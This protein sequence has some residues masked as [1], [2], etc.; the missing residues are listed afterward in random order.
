[1]TSRNRRKTKKPK[2]LKTPSKIKKMIKN[3]KLKTSH[4]P[5][6]PSLMGLA[7]PVFASNGLDHW[8]RSE[9]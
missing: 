2:K 5:V 6:P 1:M 9:R 4:I 7:Q 8:G 3:S